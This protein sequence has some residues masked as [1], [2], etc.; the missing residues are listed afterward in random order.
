MEQYSNQDFKLFTEEVKKSISKTNRAIA[1]NILDSTKCAFNIPN[2]FESNYKG[3]M[4]YF[5]YGLCMAKTNGTLEDIL[6]HLDNMEM[7]KE[8]VPK[9][10]KIEEEKIFDDK[11]FEQVPK[12][13]NNGNMMMEMIKKLSGVVTELAKDV[14][15]L[16]KGET[17]PIIKKGKKEVKSGVE[18][19][20]SFKDVKNVKVVMK[21][22]QMI[23]ME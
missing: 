10:G 8:K 12:D 22:A 1:E 6:K 2:I 21:R 19:K 15:E 5:I 9:T 14:K 13:L 3:K 18:K 4:A 23:N 20:V 11:V 7:L 16:K 17:K